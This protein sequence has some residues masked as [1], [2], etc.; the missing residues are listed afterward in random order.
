MVCCERHTVVYIHSATFYPHNPHHPNECNLF[1]WHTHTLRRICTGILQRSTVPHRLKLSLESAT[2]YIYTIWVTR[3]PQ[4]SHSSSR[5]LYSRIALIIGASSPARPKR[6][7][8]SVNSR[9]SRNFYVINAAGHTPLFKYTTVRYT[10]PTYL[11]PDLPGIVT[12]LRINGDLVTAQTFEWRWIFP[13][14]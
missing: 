5:P 10:L 9:E 13:R 12:E 1:C 8:R 6:C 4:F 11:P 2:V 3:E 14:F 7:S